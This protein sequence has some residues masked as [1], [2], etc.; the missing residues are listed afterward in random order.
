[1]EN[2]EKYYTPVIEEFH[3]GFE[4]EY[5]LRVRNGIFAY[6]DGI[7]KYY[8]DSWTKDCFMMKDPADKP[9]GEAFSDPWNINEENLQ[10]S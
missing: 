3:V 9:F 6:M 1:M 4:Y 2:K 5:K 7:H 10:C 8:P